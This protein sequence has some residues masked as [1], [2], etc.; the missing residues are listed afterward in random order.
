[1][2]RVD[3]GRDAPGR[4]IENLDRNLSFLPNPPPPPLLWTEELVDISHRATQAV[5]QVCGIGGRFPEPQRLI[6]LFLRRE[7]ELSSRIEQTHAS[8]RTMLL[9]DEHALSVDPSRANAAREVANNYEVLRAGVDSVSN[10]RPI[11]LGLLRALHT[12]LFRGTPEAVRA[13][14]RPGKFRSIPVFIGNTDRIDDARFVPPPPLQVPACMDAL[15]AFVRNPGRLPAVV[16][17]AIAHYQFEAIHPFN[18]GNGRVGRALILMMLVGDGLLPVPL[19]NPSAGL[20]RRRRDYYDRL[21]GV[22]LAGEWGEWIKFFCTCV[23]EEARH[24][25]TLLEQLDGLR[26]SF[27]DRVRAARSSALLSKLIDELFASP[28]QTGAS[29]AKLLSITPPTAYKAIQRL[30]D[31]GIIQ[32][33]TGRERDR[34]FMATEIVDLFSD[35]KSSASA[36]VAPATRGR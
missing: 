19:L 11:S 36:P 3:F 24:T 33:V 23:Y 1:M 18:D 34:V 25:M 6:R 8:V 17:A 12:E 16:R 31:L 22:S 30:A 4:L 26:V 15:E 2:R 13:H 10:G 28:A 7:A 32:E 27:H 14:A 29:V 5:A 20:E 21:L 35:K 9:L